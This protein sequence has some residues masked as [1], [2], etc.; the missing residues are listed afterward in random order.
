MTSVKWGS[1]RGCVIAADIFPDFFSVELTKSFTWQKSF[2]KMWEFWECKNFENLRIKQFLTWKKVATITG[3]SANSSVQP[4]LQV[5]G[6]RTYFRKDRQIDTRTHKRFFLFL[7]FEVCYASCNISKSISKLSINFWRIPSRFCKNSKKRL[8]CNC[9]FL[10]CASSR[11]QANLECKDC[12][13]SSN[14]KLSGWGNNSAGRNCKGCL[15]LTKDWDKYWSSAALNSKKI[16]YSLRTWT[17]SSVPQSTSKGFVSR[18]RAPPY[19]PLTTDP[20]ASVRSSPYVG[21]SLISACL[22]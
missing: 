22:P 5:W 17:K 6:G 21:W 4:T 15:P 11:M 10:P 8:I 1:C 19:A 2:L 20:P 3:Q 18:K 16:S 13:N 7:G 9:K 14:V 12:F